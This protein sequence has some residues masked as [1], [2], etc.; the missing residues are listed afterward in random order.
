[1]SRLSKLMR[2]GL[3]EV[4]LS[5]PNR[6]WLTHFYGVFRDPNIRKQF[7]GM[8]LH[9]KISAWAYKQLHSKNPDFDISEEVKD[10]VTFKQI[11]RM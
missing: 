8:R 7:R 10:N 4:D 1:M 2:K 6:E 3:G 9:T 11:H 5:E